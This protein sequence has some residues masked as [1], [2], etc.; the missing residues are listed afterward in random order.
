MTTVQTWTQDQFLR[1]RQTLYRRPGDFLSIDELLPVFDGTRLERSPTFGADH[2]TYPSNFDTPGAMFYDQANDKTVVV[3]VSDAIPPSDLVAQFAIA[4]ADFS[5]S[6]TYQTTSSPTAIGGAHK[7]NVCYV[8]NGFWFI[9]DDGDVYLASD[10]YGQAAAN[11]YGSGDARA[12]V[13][14]R[15]TVYLITTSDEI[16]RWNTN[17]GTFESFYDT[18]LQIGGEYLCHYRNDFILVSYENDGACILYRIDDLPPAELR[19][20]AR[21]QPH[22]GALLPDDANAQWATP[23]ALYDDDVYFSPGA[24]ITPDEAFEQVPI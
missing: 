1:P 5:K 12:L 2:I 21:L 19:E 22:T 20:I 3:G 23:W 11:K 15:D 7:R 8:Q 17:S 24:W 9:G 13:P 4:H 16:L 6:G 14:A 10:P 18:W